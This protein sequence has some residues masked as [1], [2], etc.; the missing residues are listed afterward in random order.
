LDLHV[1]SLYILHQCFEQL[2][3]LDLEPGADAEGGGEEAPRSRVPDFDLGHTG[4]FST[5]I[6]VGP[7]AWPLLCVFISISNY[8]FGFD[9]V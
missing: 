9:L 1:L 8:Q 4:Q 2:L 5:R 6:P 7:S 3:D